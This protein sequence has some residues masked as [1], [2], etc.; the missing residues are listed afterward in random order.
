MK[1]RNHY[2]KLRRRILRRDK[3]VCQ[4]CKRKGAG[5]I[6]HIIPKSKGG[7]DT[8]E[9]LITLCGPCHL[10]LSPIPLRVLEK[11]L[12]LPRDEIRR[13]QREVKRKMAKLLISKR[14]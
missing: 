11:I 9:N 10:L 2:R 7:K 3:R 4:V 13:R 14:G 6:H 12:R 1:R 8:E 5:Q